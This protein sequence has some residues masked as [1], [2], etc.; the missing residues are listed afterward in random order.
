[1]K[2]L[3]LPLLALL[4]ATFAT[5]SVLRSHSVR[6]ATPP[7]TPPPESRF[8]RSVAAVGLVEAASE[9]ISLGTPWPGLVATVNA[10][11]GT[12][13]AP[14]DPLFE[15]DT[16]ALRADRTARAAAVDA[17]RSRIRTADSVLDDLRDQLRRAEQLSRT[18]VISTEELDRRRFAE[19]TAEARRDEAR[20]ELAAAEAALAVVDTDLERAVIRAPIAGEVLQ[21]NVRPGEYATPSAGSRPP[22]ILGNL[23]PLHV[24]VDVDEHEGWRVSPSAPAEGHIRGNPRQPVPL[25]FV[26]V[27]P[28]VIPKR[29]LTGDSTERV[30]TRVLQVLYAVDSTPN[31]PLFVGQQLDVFIAAPPELGSTTP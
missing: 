20:A 1:M 6:T 15:L 30:D 25:R 8:N 24:R 16:R 27:E 28:L 9:N 4:A 31:V 18:A 3:G 13:V 19:R 29:S 22:V 5:V 26:R 12:V 23:R 17:A 11:V 2:S 7:P 10:Q 21:V 14:G